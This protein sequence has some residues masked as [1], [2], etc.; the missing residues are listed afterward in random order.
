[1]MRSLPISEAQHRL[2][3][4]RQEIV[5][6]NGEVILTHEG[7]NI[8]MIS[9]Q[10][11]ENMKETMRIINNKEILESLLESQK[12]RRAGRTPKGKTVSQVFYDL[13]NQHSE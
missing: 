11:W 6:E 10:D 4:L 9:Q 1:M 8:V 3:E 7:G 12:E 5:R 2:D 13:E